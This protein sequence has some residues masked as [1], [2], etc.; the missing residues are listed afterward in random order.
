VNVA[1]WHVLTHYYS[2]NFPCEFLQEYLLPYSVR[3]STEI[4]GTYVPPVLTFRILHFV[5]SMYFWMANDSQK[6][7]DTISP[8]NINQFVSVMEMKCGPVR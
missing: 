5:Y 3:H 4:T 2:L 8:N 1:G 6:E 7:T